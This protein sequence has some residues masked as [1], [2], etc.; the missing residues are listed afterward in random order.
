MK[1]NKV[2]K[3]FIV[4]LSGLFTSLSAFSTDASINNDDDFSV[5]LEKYQEYKS[6]NKEN[7]KRKSSTKIS[8]KLNFANQCYGEQTC[9]CPQ[10][11]TYLECLTGGTVFINAD[12]KE[13]GSMGLVAIMSDTESGDDGAQGVINTN[14]HWVSRTSEG[15]HYTGS[16][17]NL[18][19]QSVYSFSVNPAPIA[20]ACR[21]LE[22]GLRVI[23]TAGLGVVH[24]MDVEFSE[25]MKA[26]PEFGVNFDPERF[27]YTKALS[28]GMQQ[29]KYIPIGA[30][31]C[32]DGYRIE[33]GGA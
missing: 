17:P 30:G 25:R 31:T 7:N 19:S 33:I 1:I 14:G 18:S 23:V 16:V 5:F 13:S 6:N 11:N 21:N 9:K 32:R 15:N 28:N 12:T 4:G 24:P 22:A 27:I 3:I 26:H 10:G 20:A 29:R 8:G 2:N